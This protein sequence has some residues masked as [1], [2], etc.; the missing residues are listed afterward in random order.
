MSDFTPSLAFVCGSLR[1]GS[2]NK[3]LEEAL[4]A[5]AQDHGA[6]AE[7]VSLGDYDMPIYHGDLETPGTVPAL[8]EK[9]AGFDGIIIVTPEYNGSLPPLLKNAVD[10][11][12]TVST[13]WI[14]GQSFGIASC[15]PGPMSGIMCL[16]ELSFLLR[17]LGG[18]VVPTQ[19]G[20]G[21]AGTA[22]D[23]QGTL[24]GQPASDLADDMLKSVIAMARRKQAVS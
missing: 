1:R 18:D 20:V 24:I 16:R 17:R 8:I 3:K 22:F 5:R 21:N 19:V 9:L 2:I 14:K 4:I 12:S 7:A 10:W 13:R 11:T 23:A 15:T 6:R